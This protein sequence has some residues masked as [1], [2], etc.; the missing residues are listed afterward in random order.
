MAGQEYGD[1]RAQADDIFDEIDGVYEQYMTQMG[2]IHLNNARAFDSANEAYKLLQEA[3]EHAE[4]AA[5]LA[6]DLDYESLFLRGAGLIAD[7]KKLIA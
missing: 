1:N 6:E 2:E 4:K 3:V 7:L 5:E